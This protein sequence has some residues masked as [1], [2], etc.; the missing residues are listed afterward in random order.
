M[1]VEKEDEE[2]K[3]SR[4]EQEQRDR[5]EINNI[6][7]DMDL[8]WEQRK[9]KERE[10]IVRKRGRKPDMEGAQKPAKRLR[11]MKYK[12]IGEEWGE[13]AD[14]DGGAIDV[15]EQEEHGLRQRLTMWSRS[16]HCQKKGE[17][18]RDVGSK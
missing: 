12:L 11:K 1:V 7:Q 14:Y 2:V 10:L 9:E 6:L 13:G 18:A 5:E 17:G 3:K 16:N 15:R 4:L 8:S